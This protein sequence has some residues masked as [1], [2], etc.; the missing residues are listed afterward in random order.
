[1]TETF[2]PKFAVV[3]AFVVMA[4]DLTQAERHIFEVI[5][6]HTDR[7]GRCWPSRKRIADITGTC[8]MTVKRAFKKFEDK[9]WLMRKARFNPDGSQATNEIIVNYQYVG[10]G[11]NTQMC[12][13]PETPD[14][15]QGGTLRCSP[16]TTLEH[17]TEHNSVKEPT[18]AEPAEPSPETAT[19]RPPS[20]RSVDPKKWVYEMGRSVLGA[21]GVS[22]SKAGAMVTKWLRKTKPLDLIGILAAA[23]EKERD[24]IVAFISGGIRNGSAARSWDDGR[25]MSDD[26]FNAMVDRVCSQGSVAS[27]SQ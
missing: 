22:S 8:E 15:P 21:Y 19:L 2:V 20:S 14:V 23:A 3:P 12:P 18:A 4:R 5:C 26:D 16:N 25:R 9:Q 13:T 27:A 11:G 10:E 7:Y 24:D 1:M 17:Y 6:L